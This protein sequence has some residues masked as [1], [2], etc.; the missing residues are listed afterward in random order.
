VTKI[1]DDKATAVLVDSPVSRFTFIHVNKL[2]T[3]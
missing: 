2:I 1:F 3:I